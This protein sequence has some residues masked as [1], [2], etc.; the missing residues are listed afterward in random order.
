MA[1]EDYEIRFF[2]ADGTLSHVLITNCASDQDARAAALKKFAEDLKRFE[3]WRGQ[4]LIETG[5]H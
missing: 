3:I 4:T 1:G 2:N 5:P